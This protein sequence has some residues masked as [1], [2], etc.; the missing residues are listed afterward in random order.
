MVFPPGVHLREVRDSKRLSPETR[1]ILADRIREAAV[2][3]GVGICSPDDIDRLNILWAAMEAMRRAAEALETPPDILLIDGNRCFPEPAWPVRTIVKGDLTC[4]AIAAASI[5]AKTVRDGLM[6]DLH[7][8]HPEYGWA[9]NAGYPTAAH[10]DAL[11]RHG[12]TPFHRRSFRLNRSAG[13]TSS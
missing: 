8:L 12:P 7:T 1:A 2:A 10:Y 6:Q 3:V 5:I 4:H 11:D 13:P 9:R